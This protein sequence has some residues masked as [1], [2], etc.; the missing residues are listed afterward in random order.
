MSLTIKQILAACATGE[1]PTVLCNYEPY[2]AGTRK[3]QITQISSNRVAVDFGLG[4]NLWFY[5]DETDGNV[6]AN[7]K[8]LRDLSI[9]VMPWMKVT[10]DFQI[11]PLVDDP[12]K[13]YKSEIQIDGYTISEHAD[14]PGCT[15]AQIWI[16]NEQ[17]EGTTVGIDTFYNW[18]F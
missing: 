2:G 5:V 6:V 16:E 15:E 4:Y 3:G 1:M 10:D 18:A 17:G 8:Y 13:M 12:L 14:L 9:T 11:M 7:R